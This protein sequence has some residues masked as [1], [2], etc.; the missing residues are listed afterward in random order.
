M[1]GIAKFRKQNVLFVSKN[2]NKQHSVITLERRR[3]G[4]KDGDDRN[5]NSNS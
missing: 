5:R 1:S 4:I 3:R 2:G